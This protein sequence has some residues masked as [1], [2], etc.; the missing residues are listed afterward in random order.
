MSGPYLDIYVLCPARSADA[1]RRFLDAWAP[2]RTLATAELA[3]PASAERPQLLSSVDELF[4]RLEAEPTASYLVYWRSGRADRVEHVMLAFTSDGGM[5]AGL[6]VAGVDQPRNSVLA[7]LADLATS[8]QGAFG[9]VTL[10]APPPM[11]QSELV[12]ECGQR[13]LAW[14]D[15]AIDRSRIRH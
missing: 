4:D 14:I 11:K 6:G 2:A 9:Y 15:G 10:E 13:E 12:A 1:A 8:V 3:F 7:L 5:I